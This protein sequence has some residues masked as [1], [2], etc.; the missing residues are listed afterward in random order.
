[1]RCVDIMYST[2]THSHKM[3]LRLLVAVIAPQTMN[4]TG[5]SSSSSSSGGGGC[6]HCYIAYSPPVGISNQESTSGYHAK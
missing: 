1:M 6:R 3:L 5:S 4:P 2:D